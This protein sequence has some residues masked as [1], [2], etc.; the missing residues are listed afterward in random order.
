MGLRLLSVIVAAASTVALSGCGSTGRLALRTAWVDS[1]VRF[2]AGGVT[3]YATFR[4]R[5]ADSAD[6]AALLIAGSGPTDRNGNSAL[7]GGQVDTLRAVADWLSEDGVASLRYDK[8]GSGRTGLGPYAGRA[9]RIT[10][11]PYQREAAAGLAFLARRPGVDGNRLLVIG[12]SEGALYALWLATHDGGGPPITGLGLLEPLSIRYIDLLAIQFT[13]QLAAAER[14]GAMTAAEVDADRAALRRAVVSLRTT[15]RLPRDL[16][17]PVI[18]LLSPPMYVARIDRYDPGALASQLP[19]Q[20]PV[21]LTCSDSDVQVSCAE[22]DHLAAGLTHAD[23]DFVHLKG[24]DHV[25]KEDPSGSI[26][27]YA[28]PL[29]FSTQLRARLHAF[30]SA[31]RLR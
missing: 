5:P 7:E 29:P 26:A 2:H 11:T 25:L 31:H 23:T 20:L 21:V 22:V 27:N 28:K 18:T 1:P 16:P 14:S 30:L 9:D 17:P 10:P 13:G 15:G 24:V 8:L 3:I 4:H 6:A 12:H 19:A